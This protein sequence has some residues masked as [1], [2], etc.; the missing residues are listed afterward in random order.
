MRRATRRAAI[1]M[2]GLGAVVF[3]GCPIDAFI[4]G[5]LADCFGEDTISEGEYDDLNIF[6]RLLYDE[7]NCGRYERVGIFGGL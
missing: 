1:T 2:L 7:N 3:Q 5:F 4:G 6:E